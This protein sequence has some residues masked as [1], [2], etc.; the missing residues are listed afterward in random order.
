MYNAANTEWAEPTGHT[1]LQQ[2]PEGEQAG[3]GGEEHTWHDL[4]T[5]LFR[6]PQSSSTGAARG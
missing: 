6:F 3:E 2:Q 5:V 1:S 4:A